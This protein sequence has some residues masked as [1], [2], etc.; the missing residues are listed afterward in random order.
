MEGATDAEA[1]GIARRTV[2]SGGISDT[3][4]PNDM[5]ASAFADAPE[6]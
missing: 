1:T 5:L 4:L 2:D 6:T 3:D